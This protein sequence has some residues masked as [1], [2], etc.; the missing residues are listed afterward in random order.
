MR[1]LLASFGILLAMSIT[2]VGQPA[3][4]WAIVASVSIPDHEVIPYLAKQFGSES[5]CEEFLTSPTMDEAVKA[6]LEYENG[7]HPSEDN[8]SIS[9]ECAMIGHR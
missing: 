3:S 5:E 7:H 6:L 4:I 1:T 8:L 2:S 9:V